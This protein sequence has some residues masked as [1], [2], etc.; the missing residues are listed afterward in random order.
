MKFVTQY[1]RKGLEKPKDFN[2][3]DNVQRQYTDLC[4]LNNIMD[5]YNDTKTL[6]L[7]KNLY[8]ENGVNIA[9]FR[10]SF[11]LVN[12]L[13]TEFQQLPSDIRKQFGNDLFSYVSY[14]SDAYAGN[15]S[16]IDFLSNLGLLHTPNKV[17]NPEVVSQSGEDVSVHISPD[18]SKNISDLM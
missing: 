3:V 14:L 13:K 7:K 11:N 12:S 17:E 4:D 5:N 15:Q 2:P 6:P 9:D 18:D 1:N 16:S 8:S 10:S